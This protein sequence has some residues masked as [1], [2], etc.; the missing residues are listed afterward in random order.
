MKKVG[1]VTCPVSDD[2]GNVIKRAI[3]AKMSMTNKIA[4]QR[5]FDAYKLHPEFLGI[6]IE[7]VEQR[8]AL[9]SVLLHIASRMGKL[10]HIR[11]L[12]DAGADI[13]A[14]GYLDNTPLHD[15][16]LC[17]Q[18]QAVGLLLLLGANASLKNEFGQTALDVAV[19]GKKEAVC[20]TLRK[21]KR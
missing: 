10:D 1:T 12:V 11:T 15:A 16:A 3:K 7:E 13:N 20:E 6:D 21:M 4:L 8:G 19:L 5:I 17:G 18:A 14:R 9:D 2:Q